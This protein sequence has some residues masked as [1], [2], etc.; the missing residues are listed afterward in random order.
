MRSTDWYP[1]Y[2]VR[3]YD[4]RAARWVGTHVHEGVEVAGTR[5]PAAPANCSTSPYRDIVAPPPDDRP[6]HDARGPADARGRPAGDGPAGLAAPARAAPS[7][8]TTCCA[9]AA[10]TASVGLIVSVLN[11]YYVF[12]KFAKLWER[13]RTNEQG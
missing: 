3:L 2:Q 10:A 4:R 5:R 1:D 11:S 9:A 6:L 7:C 12:L 8:A 13:Q